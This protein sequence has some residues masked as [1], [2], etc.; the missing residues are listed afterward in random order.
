MVIERAFGRLKARFRRLLGTI[1]QRK[2]LFISQIIM[3]CVLLHNFFIVNADDF[4][5]AG[6]VEPDETADGGVCMIP[7]SPATNVT[8][9][10]CTAVK[11]ICLSGAKILPPAK[12]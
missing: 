7:M 4:D 10:S 1:R 6:L 5:D 8:C 2:R 12:Y 3:A 11:F 9:C